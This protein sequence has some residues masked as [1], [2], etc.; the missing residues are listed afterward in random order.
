MRT[1]PVTPISIVAPIFY[2]ATQALCAMTYIEAKILAPALLI[3]Y[4]HTAGQHSVESARAVFRRQNGGLG[5][6]NDHTPV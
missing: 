2:L 5:G 3:T 1:V 6:A 4:T